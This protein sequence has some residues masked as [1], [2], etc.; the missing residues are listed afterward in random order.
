VKRQKNEAAKVVEFG[1]VSL[2][3]EKVFQFS[4]GVASL[5]NQQVRVG[6]YSFSSLQL[7]GVATCLR[8][9]IRTFDEFRVSH[10]IALRG[11]PCGAWSGSFDLRLA[12]RKL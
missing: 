2:R 5:V 10:P 3:I 4:I 8:I 1:C 11:N 12:F 7:F 9:C 6:R